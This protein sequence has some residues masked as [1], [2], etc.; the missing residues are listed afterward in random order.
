MDSESCA[1]TPELEARAL[2]YRYPSGEFELAALDV[3]FP[4]ASFTVVPKLR[5]V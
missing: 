3:V 2:E 1:V 4:A 5:L